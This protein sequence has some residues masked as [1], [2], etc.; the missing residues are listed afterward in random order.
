MAEN[1]NIPQFM[2]SESFM[3]DKN[4]V[5][6]LS[7]L[8]KRI[9]I[10]QLKAAVRVNEEML[11]LYWGLGEDIC[12]KQKQ[13]HWGTAF[14]KRL[15]VDLRTE[16]P[17]TEGFSWSNLYKIR[18]WYLYYSAQIEFLYQAGTKLLT[19]ENASVSMPEI[20]LRVPWKH[21]TH[22]VSKCKT[23]QEAIF[24]LNQVIEGNIS[25][26]ELEHIIDANLYEHKAKALNNFESTLPQ[27]QG[28][29]AEEIIKDPYNLD[30]I[31]MEGKF[32]ER[33][34]ENK[35]AE[36]VT[37]F[38]L[39]LG[40]GFAYVGRQMELVTPSGKSYFPD[41]VFYHIKLKCYVVIELKVVDFIPEFIGKLNFY[42][43]A[44]DELLK[45]EDDN[46][47]IGILLCKD[48]DSSV[49]EWSLRGVTTPLGVASYQL[50]EV[51]ERTMLEIRQR[52]LEEKQDE[53][54]NE[55]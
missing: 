37:R 5:K 20:L 30:F 48:K 2:N 39:E 53:E 19:V 35:L 21:Q 14:I 31:S 6:W 47:S 9:R 49:V 50:Q 45:G 24:Y 11:K 10:A 40:K 33:D 41:M 54:K 36:N 25:R 29:L 38:L 12:E 4:Y 34:L 42:V 16:F 52:T 13:H 23:I 44:A 43:S 55:I 26:S 32:D 51:Y 22:I 18:Q 3:S 7:D 28:S 17:H 8:K 27:P 15:S 46:P 1:N